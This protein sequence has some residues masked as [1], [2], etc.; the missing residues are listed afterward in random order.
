[1]AFDPSQYGA[2]PVGGASPTTGAAPTQSNSSFNPSQFGATPVQSQT[3][4]QSSPQQTSDSL[5]Q[6]IAGGFSSGI[7]QVKQGYQQAQ[8]A[9]NPLQKT[10][11]G[12]SMLAGGVGAAFSPL[13]PV[14][15]AI[16]QATKPISDALSNTPLIKGAAGNQVVGP[17]GVA[18]Y[19]PNMAADRVP[20][21]LAN[22]ATV[23][24]VAAGV[25][26]PKELAANVQDTASNIS[27]KIQGT[28]EQQAAAQASANDAHIQSV[29]QDWQ[30]ASEQPSPGFTK[31]RA[32][33]AKD[34]TAPTTLA[35]N[36]INPFA[37]IEDGK[38]VT[39][40]TA[41][42]LRDT[43]SKL[44]NDTV[45]PALQMA[46]YQTPPTPVASLQD[47]ANLAV[48]TFPN[49]TAGDSAAIESAI[50]KEVAALQAKYPDGMSLENMHDEK[51]TYSQ[52]AGYNQFKSN[53][54]TNTALANKA[55]SVT[56]KDAIEAGVPADAPVKETNAYIGKLYSAA[57]Y[58]D[59]LNNKKA[60]VNA[61]Q[62][63]A[64]ATS[65]FGGAA[66][67]AHFGPL[68]DIVS[69]FAGYQIGKA[70]EAMLE[71][72]TNAG[73]AEFLSN[74]SHTNPA[75]VTQLQEFAS[76]LSPK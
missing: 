67:A 52:N 12:M 28:P 16:N 20:Q 57:D 7:N 50:A 25:L 59:S 66:L 72:L 1:M 14:G 49:V 29:T 65:K 76:K 2:T 15:N 21:D 41:Q 71:N 39:T 26:A 60:P 45:R 69:P 6:Q 44:S 54:D 75:A 53:A 48:K 23:L 40:D 33:L 3:Q 68:G 73:R 46:D 19:K 70:A 9:T 43:A 51:I 4:T 31:A 35:Q 22:T 37:N 11:A 56:L 8:Q 62:S 74:M 5:W 13:A 61:L 34:P 58:L 42:A 55:I 30:K 64:R 38:Y 17:G 27:E 36:G 32:V 18:Q 63:V 47:A 10:E 24:P